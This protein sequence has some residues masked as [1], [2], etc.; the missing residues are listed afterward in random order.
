MSNWIFVIAMILI[1]ILS[2]FIGLTRGVKETE[3]E[4]L[5]DYDKGYA[6]A[7]SY[8]EQ[9][10]HMEEIDPML[11]DLYEE[12]KYEKAKQLVKE[13]DDLF[14]DDNVIDGGYYD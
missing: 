9:R 14:E 5:M 3:A 10:Y 11:N 13:L 4:H 7:L 2:Y 6:D 8:C 12:Q 1:G